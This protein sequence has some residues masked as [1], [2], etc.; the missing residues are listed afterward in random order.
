[1]T[2]PRR[3]KPRRYGRGLAL[4]LPLIGR[5]RSSHSAPLPAGQCTPGDVR[6]LLLNTRAPASQ[7]FTPDEAMGIVEKWAHA[8]NDL[9]RY[10]ISMD[11]ARQ[12]DGRMTITVTPHN[13]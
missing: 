6:N 7:S 2:D 5:W 12:S 1:M 11:V 4:S 8:L 3:P 13:A 10:P 9:P